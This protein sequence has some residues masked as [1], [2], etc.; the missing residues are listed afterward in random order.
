MCV[1]LQWQA[2]NACLR[3]PKSVTKIVGVQ[4]TIF[5]SRC[6]KT[7]IFYK[8]Y[9]NFEAQVWNF[10]NHHD[11]V[12]KINTQRL[13]L[14]SLMSSS[15]W[16]WLWRCTHCHFYE[17]IAIAMLW[18]ISWALGFGS[19]DYLATCFTCFPAIIY[20]SSVGKHLRASSLTS[21]NHFCKLASRVAHKLMLNV[22][23]LGDSRVGRSS[24]SK[25]YGVLVVSLGQNV[26]G[27]VTRVNLALAFRWW[28]STFFGRG[29]SN[30]PEQHFAQSL[31]HAVI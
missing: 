9:W 23:L 19:R 14:F 7:V 17:H 3:P 29:H 10:M 6:G 25:E 27:K 13:Q 5:S 30:I 24:V 8:S 11:G 22:Q 2:K 18:H 21:T 15:W 31:A 4:E 12:C 1:L 26:L 16:F 20:C 28:L